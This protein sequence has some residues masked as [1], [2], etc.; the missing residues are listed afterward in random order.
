MIDEWPYV[1]AAYAATWVAVIGY[2]IHL[3][4]VVR[5]AE[6]L[7]DQAERGAR[8]AGPMGQTGGPY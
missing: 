3:T 7:R 1:I 2:A 4:R 8:P 5:R 6:S